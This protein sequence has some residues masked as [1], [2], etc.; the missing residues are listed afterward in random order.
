MTASDG[1]GFHNQPAQR[2]YG[3][4]LFLMAVF[5]LLHTF[6]VLRSDQSVVDFRF[7]DTDAYSRMVR[8]QDLLESGN[9]FDSS[10]RRVNPPLGHVSHWTRPMDAVILTE[11]KLLTLFLDDETALHW[12][13]VTIGPVL[14]L[15]C[16]FVL[17]LGTRPL[18]GSMY[19][20]LCGLLFLVQ[21]PLVQSFIMGRPD[22]TKACSFSW[23]C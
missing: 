20:T 23:R 3:S 22:P 6:V 11:A 8:V 13:G 5:V 1:A 19:S 2:D 10:Y 18:F 9:W 12:A 17:V 7:T 14:H 4:L 15:L 21:P 16:L